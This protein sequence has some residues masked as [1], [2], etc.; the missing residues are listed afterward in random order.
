[1][2]LLGVQIALAELVGESPP[3]LQGRSPICHATGTASAKDSPEHNPRSRL[4][5]PPSANVSAINKPLA[6]PPA[7]PP[8]AKR[9]RHSVNNNRAAISLSSDTVT[10]PT[11]AAPQ[12][13]GRNYGLAHKEDSV[14]APDTGSS[15]S[16]SLVSDQLGSNSV[17][18]PS[19]SATARSKRK[20]GTPL[21]FASSES[22]AGYAAGTV[23][24]VQGANS[25]GVKL[26]FVVHCSTAGVSHQNITPNQLPPSLE[27][28]T[29]P[30]VATPSRRRHVPAPTGDA[31]GVSEFLGD[32]EMETARAAWRAVFHPL[33]RHTI[34]G[35]CM[36]AS[37]QAQHADTQVSSL[38]ER[39]MWRRR[40]FKEVATACAF[41]SF[42]FQ[43]RAVGTP[44]IQAHC[45]L[46]CLCQRLL[47][48][49]GVGDGGAT[50]TA[51][52]LNLSPDEDTFF[53]KRLLQDAIKTY[54]EV[55][56]PVTRWCW[57]CECLLTPWASAGRPVAVGSYHC[58][59]K[60]S[61]TRPANCASCPRC[62]RS[63]QP[64]TG[65]EAVAASVVTCGRVSAEGRACDSASCL[66]EGPVAA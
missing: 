40:Q 3:A 10:M 36:F 41:T 28:P 45:S 19:R 20:R 53:S 30:I 29:A 39:D 1:M 33:D 49:H 7:Q 4:D 43:V 5:P 25:A 32:E 63:S 15:V 8:S 51:P 47:W 18:A 57:V 46:P 27:S 26:I 12:A 64:S 6:P 17:S 61:N 66:L 44:T 52:G 65:G 11:T 16:A 60:D 21:L 31:L 42:H 48:L 58:T 9:A 54:V 50:P 24:H 14:T 37:V 55:R 22:P 23:P 62:H 59:T 34:A 13:L 38:G 35:H 56:L 2:A